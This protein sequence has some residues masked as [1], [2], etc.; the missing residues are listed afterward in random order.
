MAQT[1]TFYPIVEDWAVSNDPDRLPI[2]KAP[3]FTIGTVHVFT[4]NSLTTLTQAE[5]FLYAQTDTYNQ[6]DIGNVVYNSGSV[7]DSFIYVGVNGKTGPTIASDWTH[8]ESTS[9]GITAIQA[10][11]GLQFGDGTGSQ[12]VAAGH[13]EVNLSLLNV[14]GAITNLS[15]AHDGLIIQTMTEAQYAGITPDAGTLYLL[16]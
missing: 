14:S 4:D 11:Q 12:D 16:T 7:A 10:G 1:N 9:N 13:P 2:S 3:D 5:T 8:L 15:S 6:G